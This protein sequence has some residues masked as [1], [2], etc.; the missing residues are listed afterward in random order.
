MRFDLPKP[1]LDALER[2]NQSGHSA[3]I[4]GG[5]VRDMLRGVAPHDYDICTSALPQETHACFAQER[6]IDTGLQHGTVTVLLAGMALEI[7][8]FRFDGEYLDGRHPQ[9]VYFSRCLAEDL[10]RRDF[11]VNA[12]AYHPSE[13]LTDLFDGQKDLQRRLIRCVGGAR[14]RLTEDALRILRAVRFAAQLDFFIEPATAAAMR[15]L[16]GRLAL[17]SRERVAEE[18]LHTV[19]AAHAP[20]VLTDFADVLLAALPEYEPAALAEGIAALRRLPAGDAALRLAALLHACGGTARQRC[21]D[22]LHPARA[23]AADTLTLAEEAKRAFPLP[24][25]ALALSRLGEARLRRLLLL[26]QACGTLSVQEAAARQA[27]MEEALAQ[28]LPLRVRD[29]AV[30]GA[31]AQALG[32]AGAQIGQAL[33][34]LHAAVLRGEKPNEREA[35]LACL[36]E[37]RRD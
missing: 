32:L 7:T 9:R 34:A 20:D 16:R 30:S 13:G 22:S 27:R 10:Q 31:D 28:K 26:Q 12:M 23:F 17:V 6:V 4:V 29:L 3:Y 14:T 8:T 1:V 19:R 35:L 33:E 21:V 5:C 25:T 18:L 36:R 2:L 15:A 24:D 37:I 11:T